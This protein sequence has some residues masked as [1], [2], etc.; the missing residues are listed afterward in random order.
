MVSS[1]RVQGSKEDYEYTWNFF[2]SIGGFLD[3]IH[4]SFP[5]LITFHLMGAKKISLIFLH[6]S[7]FFFLLFI[8]FCGLL[9]LLLFLQS[10]F[11]DE[12]LLLFFYYLK[13]CS[14]ISFFLHRS[15]LACLLLIIHRFPTYSTK[16]KERIRVWWI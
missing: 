3:F 1:L 2:F 12:F 11:D 13:K 6:A 4:L 10:H 5:I 7:S 8:F 15:F 16:L 9:F 14:S